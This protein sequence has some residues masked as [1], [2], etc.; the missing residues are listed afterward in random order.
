MVRVFPYT[1][2]E[3]LNAHQINN[4]VLT[5]KSR[6]RIISSFNEYLKDGAFPELTEITNKK[7][8]LNSIYQTIY[9]G[10][11]ISKHKISNDFAMRLIMKKIAEAVMKPLSYNR[12]TNILKSAGLAVGKQTVINYIEYA[13][14]SFLIFSISNF[15]SKLID[16]ETSPKYYFMDN[17]LINLLLV[18]NNDS[19]LLENLTAIELLR[20]YGEDNVFYFEKNIEVDFVIPERNAAY[21][22]CL[23]ISDSDT[24]DRET[25]AFI[26]LKK[27]LPE[28]KCTILTFDEEK[29]IE[30]DG[31][32]IQIVPMWK[33]MM[34]SDKG[35]A[36]K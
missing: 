28:M 7:D 13:K 21:Q 8:Y 9:L 2:S 12:L 23:D 35:E 29:D 27:F 31:V 11:I 1:F 25:K 3:Y 30:V 24:F 10:D 17:G 36:L 22:V 20:R 18:G 32:A 34:D 6:A 33:W 15:A 26:N 5:T 4:N 14:E 19:V 16:K